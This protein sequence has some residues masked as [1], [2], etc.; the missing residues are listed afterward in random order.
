[1]E[2]WMKILMKLGGNLSKNFDEFSVEK[3]KQ[4]SLKKS[5]KIS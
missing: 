1:M 4:I 3:S 5:I 2:I